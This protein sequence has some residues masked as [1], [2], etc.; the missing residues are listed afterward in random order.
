MRLWSI[1]SKYLDRAGLIAVWREGLLAQK[2]LLQG[3]YKTCHHCE[4]C[5]GY[6]E[7][8]PECKGAGKIRTPYWNHPQLDRFKK[9]VKPIEVIGHYLISIYEEGRLRNYRFEFEKIIHRAGIRHYTPT[10]TKG[11]LIYELAHL[12]RKLETRDKIMY[13]KNWK[14]VETEDYLWEGHIEPHPLFKV[15]EGKIESWERIK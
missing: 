11:Q 4:G 7:Y 2:V 1:H 10:V 8:C 3:E 9:C 5:L 12:Q 13:N 6:G 14:R 15:I